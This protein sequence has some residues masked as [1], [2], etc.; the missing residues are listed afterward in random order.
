MAGSSQRA[1]GRI[2]AQPRVVAQI[3]HSGDAQ[4]EHDRL[5]EGVVLGITTSVARVRV[6]RAS[7]AARHRPGA[8]GVASSIR[9]QNGKGEDLLPYSRG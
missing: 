5:D 3:L 2:A 1:G 4:L 7:S 8:E 9:G 6:R